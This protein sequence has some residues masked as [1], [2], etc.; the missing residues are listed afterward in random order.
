MS[1]SEGLQRR[2]LL[3]AGGA[4][5]TVSLLGGCGFQLRQPPPLP[6]RS[7]ALTGF[8]PRSPL[9]D[10][11]RKALALQLRVLDVPADARNSADVV[12]HAI[13]DTRERSVVAQTSSAQVRD[14]QLR[15]KLQFRAHTPS[16]R[17]LLPASILLLARDMSFNETVALAKAQEEAE[18][19]REMQ[20]DIVAQVLRRLSAIKL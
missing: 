3:C 13:A 12:L 17:E 1:S 7:I 20:S 11:L 8:A 14:V 10:E 19:Y 9:A 5:T 18:L 2:Q 4:F 6:F 15:V 16:G